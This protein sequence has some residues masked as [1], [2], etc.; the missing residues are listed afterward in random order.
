MVRAGFVYWSALLLAMALLV[1]TACSNPPTDSSTQP[2]TLPRAADA[3]TT[4]PAPVPTET[5]TPEPTAAPTPTPTP[6]PTPRP[7]P[8]PAPTLGPTAEP[9][10]TPAGERIDWTPCGLFELECGFVEVPVDYRDP[11]A[12]SIRIAVNVHRA[13]AQHKRIGYLLVNPGGPGESG[14]ELVDYVPLGLFPDEL[15]AR[16]DI[17]GFDPRGVG[18]SEPAFAC[19]GPGEQLALLAT[20]DGTIDTP[21]EIAAGEAAANLC[22]QSMGPVGGLLQSEYVANDMDE[23]RKALGA[24]QVSYLGFSYGS[25]LGVW[26]ATLFPDSVRAMVVDGADNPIDPAATRQERIDEAIEE[27]API[28][29]L[30]EQALTACAGPRCPIYNDGDPIGYFKQAVTKLDLVNSAAD[31]HPLAGLFGVISTLY[32]ETTWPDLWLG[33][34]EL[35]ENDDP[36]TLL[37]FAGIQLGPDPTA[38]SFT[39]HVNCLDGWVLYP[40]LDRATR[41]EDS[42]IAEDIFEEMFPLLALID[43]SFPSPCLFYDQFAPDPLDGPLDGGGVPILVIGN[44]SDPFTPFS[45]SEELVTETLDNGYLLEVSHFKHVVYPDDE[46]VNSH[47]HR[48]LIDGVYPTERRLLCSR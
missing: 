10:T 25:A 42:I 45:E 7:T 46:C 26:Y 4:V 40:E 16:F 15:V 22:I 39:V 43:P 14:V 2:P 20:I 17:V 12:G 33:L 21:D 31:N 9:E 35:N 44:H 28:A 1:S 23:I 48:V 38:A 3:A 27:V 5:P 37:G 18:A 19:G 30:L 41:L 29:A 24:D 47:V 6:L 11:E 13:T 34:F 32:S 8:S 36:S